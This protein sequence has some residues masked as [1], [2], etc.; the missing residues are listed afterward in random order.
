M[1]K[2]E[3]DAVRQRD[4]LPFVEQEMLFVTEHPEYRNLTPYLS[5]TYATCQAD[6]VKGEPVDL[7]KALAHVEGGCS[8]CEEHFNALAEPV[9]ELMEGGRQH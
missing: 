7:W 6:V 3:G 8:W 9:R 1:F 4:S 5:G 2:L